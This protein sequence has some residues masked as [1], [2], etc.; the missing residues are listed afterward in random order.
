MYAVA[1]SRGDSKTMEDAIGSIAYHTF[2][3]HSKCG[4]WCSYIRDKENYDHKVIPGGFEDEGL[5]L[6]L[7]NI[8]KKLATNAQKF[9]ISLDRS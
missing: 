4:N 6:E 2:N 3:D 7:K 5:F 1:Q 9:S 8:F